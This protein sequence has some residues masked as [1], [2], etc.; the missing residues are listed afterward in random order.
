MFATQQI[1]NKLDS[2]LMINYFMH[3]IQA[4]GV[5]SGR[6]AWVVNRNSEYLDKTNLELI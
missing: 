3:E 5:L 4:L 6:F 2:H 1:V